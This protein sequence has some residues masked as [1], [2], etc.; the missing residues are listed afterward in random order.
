M[1]VGTNINVLAQT[2]Y[3]FPDYQAV[4]LSELTRA[5][6]LLGSVGGWA[7]NEVTREWGVINAAALNDPFKQCNGVTCGPEDT[8]AGVQFVHAFLEQRAGFVLSSAL[9]AGYQPISSN[10][11]IQSVSVYPPGFS[12]FQLSP[13]TL[14][15][16]NGTNLA[17]TG[18]APPAQANPLPRI[19]GPTFV[20][21]DG[22]RA[23]L[24]V[25]GGYISFQVPEDEASNVTASVVV[26][27]NGAM[28]NTA[29][30]DMWPA[31]P[32]IAAVARANGSVVA[33]GNAPVAGEVVTVYALGLGYVSPDVPL[34]A[35]PPAG[36]VATTTLEPQ[37]SL[38]GAAMN[39]QFSGLS[40]DYAGLYQINAQMPATLPSGSSATLALTEGGVVYT[41]QMALQ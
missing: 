11:Q 2:L 19:I 13:G 41:V 10:P 21:V 6:N 35:P 37:M 4:Y 29:T 16:L 34:G 40:P 3:S 14:V 9:Q 26:S 5:A 38:G 28:S 7:D 18:Q 39:V 15:L 22:V 20:A 31:S 17:P 25:T 30:V 24:L 1:T 32:V 12:T 33:A 36:T 27:V 23:P 8:L